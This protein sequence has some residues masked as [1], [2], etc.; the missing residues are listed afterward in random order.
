MSEIDIRN[1][2]RVK[3]LGKAKNEEV[4]LTVLLLPALH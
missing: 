2:S 1:S 4:S 3:Q